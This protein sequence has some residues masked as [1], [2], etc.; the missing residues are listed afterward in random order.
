MGIKKIIVLFFIIACWSCQ[1]KEDDVK[2]T[3]VEDPTKEEVQK[4]V[5]DPSEIFVYE[6]EEDP[7]DFE[8]VE[9]IC[10][11]KINENE[12]KMIRV[13]PEIISDPTSKW[14]VENHTSKDMVYGTPFSMEYFDGNKWAQ[15]R[16]N[17]DGDVKIIYIW[18]GIGFL[19]FAGKVAEFSFSYYPDPIDEG[20]LTDTR[21]DLFSLAQKF[22]N[23]KKGK[24]RVRRNFTVIDSGNYNLCAE[25]E[26]I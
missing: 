18:E 19:L 6:K 17:Y 16:F 21:L 9:C 5:E 22:N 3:S 25:F 14:V 20:R 26:I 7:S 23:G 1:N 24:Y 15:I 12:Y 8:P 4:E 13:A 11:H 2:Q 10:K